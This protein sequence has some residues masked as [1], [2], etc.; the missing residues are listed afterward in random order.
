MLFPDLKLSVTLGLSQGKQNST[1]ESTNGNL[2]NSTERVETPKKDD[3]RQGGSPKDGDQRV[4]TPIRDSEPRLETPKMDGDLPSAERSTN[5]MG[6]LEDQ[7]E[8][9]KLD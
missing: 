3:E 4:E 9:I 2:N 6:G 8:E 7:L 1:D 5:E